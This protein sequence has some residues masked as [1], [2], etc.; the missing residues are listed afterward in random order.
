MIQRIQSIFM[1]LAS[2]SALLMFF[3]PI[4]WYYGANNTLEFYAYKLHEHLPNTP[5]VFSMSYLLPLIFLTIALVGIPVVSLFN[6]KH[7]QKQYKLM[8]INV[9]LSLL[10]VGGILLFYSSSLTKVTGATASYEFGVFI[11]LIVLIF[12]FLSMRGI[13]NDIRLLRSVDRLR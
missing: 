9:L 10:A 8:R 3:F 6:Y 12:S 2:V 13:R 11:P 5:A 4:A 7:L 1:A